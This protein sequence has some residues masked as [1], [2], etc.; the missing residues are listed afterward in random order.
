MRIGCR[1]IAI[2]KGA[3]S[4]LT[5][6]NDI[7][8]FY[9]VVDQMMESYSNWDMP[10]L[11]VFYTNG[12]YEVN[13]GRHRLEMLRQLG[14]KYTK[15]VFWTTGEKDYEELKVLLNV[16]KIKIRNNIIKVAVL[17]VRISDL[18]LTSFSFPQK[19]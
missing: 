18:L 5:K 17:F 3:P 2:E 6:P 10:P 7:E 14:E 15:V 8:W 1:V 4:Y 12:Q 16:K 9:Q 13:D 19:E 11:I